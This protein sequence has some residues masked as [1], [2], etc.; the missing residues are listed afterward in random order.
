MAL[1]LDHVNVIDP[2]YATDVELAVSVTVAGTVT[3]T[4]CAAVV[5]DAL[6]QVNV[7]RLLAAVSAALVALPDVA[8]AP[9]HAPVA[10]HVV[11]FVLDHVSVVVPPLATLVRL[12]DNVTVGMPACGATVTVAFADALPPAPVHVIV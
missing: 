10:V 7:N 2:L 6:A 8:F 3:V 11:V 9:V 12:A 5:P 1:V 4:L